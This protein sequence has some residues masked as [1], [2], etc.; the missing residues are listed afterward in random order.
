MLIIIPYIAI[1]KIIM[2]NIEGLQPFA[3]L[4]SSK[5]LEKHQIHYRRYFMNAKEKLEKIWSTKK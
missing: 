5:G 3:Y 4:L 1:M 2:R